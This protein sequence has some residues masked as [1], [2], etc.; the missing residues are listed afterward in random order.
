MVI[1]AAVAV[2]WLITVESLVSPIS[3]VSNVRLLTV[4]GRL[5]NM[6]GSSCRY[7]HPQVSQISIKAG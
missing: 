6:L 5:E 1:L 4:E 2:S 7:W 3:P